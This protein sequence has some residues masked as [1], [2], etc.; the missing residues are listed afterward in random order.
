MFKFIK[1][2]FQGEEPL[3]VEEVKI[4]ELFGWVDEKLSKIDFNEEVSAYFNKIKDQKWLL[5]EKLDLLVSAE[6]DK[7]ENVE[8]KVRSIVLGHKDAYLRDMKRFKEHLNIPLEINMDEAIRFHNFLNKELDELAQR[9]AKSYQASQHLFFKPVEGVFKVIGEIN[10]LMKDFEKKIDNKNFSKINL[11]R[12]KVKELDKVEI[13]KGKLQE[14]LRLKED[15]LGRNVKGKEF[16]E[17]EIL[18]LKESEDHAELLGFQEAKK[19]NMDLKEDSIQEIHAFFSKLGRAMRK[20]ERVALDNKLVGE[21]LE[22]AVTAFE[23]DEGL[24]IV[25]VLGG[26]RNSLVSGSVDLDDKQKENALDLID[27]AQKGYLMDL[28]DNFIEILTG[29]KEIKEKLGNIGVGKLLEEAKYKLNHFSEQIMNTERE[30]AEL[31]VKVEGM[32]AGKIKEELKEMIKEVLR[33]EIK[34]V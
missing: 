7:K 26:L 29:E 16:Q 9:T 10:L 12:E 4:D 20:Y 11:I 13:L 14:D 27:K 6:I 2:I 8:E 23:N 32:D 28:K 21:Y 1:K 5:E 17:K 30:L 15:K 31:K 24:N 34:F 19:K 22:E 25:G 18:R 3:K 33:V